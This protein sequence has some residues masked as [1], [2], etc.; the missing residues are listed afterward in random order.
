MPK[1]S[2]DTFR[3]GI[4]DESDKGVRGSFKHG[5][6]LDIHGRDDVLTCKQAMA[7]IF[8]ASNTTQTGIIRHFV[9]SSDGSTYCFGSTGSIFTGLLRLQLPENPS[10][11]LTLPLILVLRDGRML[12]KTI[13]RPL[14]T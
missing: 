13:K 3:A 10:M 4:S 9:N 2:I 7:T 8:G 1:Y 6:G 12:L 11:G 14:I 5:Y